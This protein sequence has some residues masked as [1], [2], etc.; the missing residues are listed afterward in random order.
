MIP[1]LKSK[2]SLINIININIINLVDAYSFVN[3]KYK[4]YNLETKQYIL[5]KMK[6][7]INLLNGDKIMNY[8]KKLS[9]HKKIKTKFSFIRK[10]IN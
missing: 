8:K 1:K 6:K 3:K 10:R 2:N 4:I 9:F 5:S 7:Y